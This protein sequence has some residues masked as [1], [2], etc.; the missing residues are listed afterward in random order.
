MSKINRIGEKNINNFGS[1]MII[2]EYRGALDVDIYFQE[3]D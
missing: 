2:I 1:K 3:Y